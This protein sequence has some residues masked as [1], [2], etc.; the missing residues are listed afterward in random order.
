MS[1]LGCSL[2]PNAPTVRLQL[3]QSLRDNPALAAI[4]YFA[5][6]V[7]GVA[8]N[9]LSQ[10]NVGN[11]SLS[12]LKLTGQ[13]SFAFTYAEL[14]AGVSI[15][16]PLGQQHLT[17]VGF[18]DVTSP[19]SVA[20]AFAQGGLR[21]FLIAEGDLN[22][23][24]S[25]TVRLTS[26]YDSGTA[27]NLVAACPPSTTNLYGVAQ[28]NER[29]YVVKNDGATWTYQAVTNTQSFFPNFFVDSFGKLS[30]GYLHAVSAVPNLAFG[31]EITGLFSPELIASY[32]TPSKIDTAQTSDGAIYILA[33]L[34]ATAST[35]GL[36]RR[37]GPNSW[38]YDQDILVSGSSTYSDVSLIAGPSR[39]LIAAAL[40]SGSPPVL[41]VRMR[42]SAGTWE[43]AQIV[44][45]AGAQGCAAGLFSPYA[46]IDSGGFG[47]AVYRCASGGG[48]YLGYA[49]N[50]IA[51]AWSNF[52]IAGPDNTMGKPAIAID[53]AG[54][55]RAI[56]SVSGGLKYMSG[57]SAAATWNA[58]EPFQAT[59]LPLTEFAIASPTVTKVEV[60]VGTNDGSDDVLL[61][62]TLTNGTIS[63]V[64][65]VIHTTPSS[66]A[67]TRKLVAR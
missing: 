54:G 56:Y 29:I 39:T 24:Q 6:A 20:N 33:P 64:G 34:Q 52:N 38:S 10:S 9:S 5:V 43:S 23:S 1:T 62:L 37:A 50:R 48:T 59:L 51:G 65:G 66:M 47:H 12:C 46:A 53:P 57:D 61:P 36:Y 41:H 45:S 32:A 19:G 49:T 14:L 27:T 8:A 25:Q 18:S 2:R 40:R 31:H 16:L 30:L 58:P 67:L 44:S 22:P 4:P 7:S 60:L 3:P 42:N 63:A 26:T 35:L 11:R 55:L 13:V 17:L 28:E 21:T 15:V